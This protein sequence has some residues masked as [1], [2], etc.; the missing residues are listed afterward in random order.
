MKDTHP[1]YNNFSIKGDARLILAVGRK[2]VVR[3]CGVSNTLCC[4]TR[5]KN[6]NI[7]LHI[8]THS[9]CKYAVPNQAIKSL[10][11]SAHVVPVAKLCHCVPVGS[12][13][14]LWHFPEHVVPVTELC[15]CFTEEVNSNLWLFLV[16][17]VP[18]LWL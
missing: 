5:W 7:G 9:M 1:W 4:A 3:I 16:Q 15:H 13:I 2:H 12:Y 11:P 10:A 14:N 17:I 8:H 6:S 18:W